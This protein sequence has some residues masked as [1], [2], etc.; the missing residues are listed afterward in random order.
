MTVWR[1]SVEQ[2]DGTVHDV[3]VDA[4]DEATVAE[5][6]DELSDRGFDCRGML[7]DGIHIDDETRL[8][9]SPLRHGSRISAEVS[10]ESLGDG[11]Y[12]VAVAGPDT[13]AWA[14]MKSEPLTVGR[15]ASNGLAVH[16]QALSRTHFEASVVDGRI[17]IDDRGSTNGTVVE[18]DSIKGRAWASDGTYV[19]AGETT[20]GVIHVDAATI[21]PKPPIVGAA[22][23]FQR[24]F[25]D[26]LEPLP[27]S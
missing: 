10:G 7:V 9:D 26:A 27:R 15:A 23:P 25:R 12:L 11:W 18:G 13:G 20:F 14:A 2:H 16:D 22:E 6:W 19:E 21:T 5:L 17:A 1:I 4:T 24:R 3:L 8:D